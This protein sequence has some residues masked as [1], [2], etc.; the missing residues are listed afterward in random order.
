M[1]VDT[2]SGWLAIFITENKKR[3]AVIFHFYSTLNRMLL[4][5]NLVRYFVLS[6]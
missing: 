1:S 5:I 6:F 2:V 3:F 4:H